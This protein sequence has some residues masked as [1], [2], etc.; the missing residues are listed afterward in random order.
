MAGVSSS[1]HPRP[2]QVTL[3]GWM[4][5][6]GSVLVVFSVVEQLS[7]MRSLETRQAVETFLDEP[8]G[9]ALGL[10]VEAVLTLWRTAALV[11]AGCATAAVVLGWHVLRRHRGARVG[12]TVLALPLFLTGVATG[13]F[14][15]ALVAAASLM[16]WMQP[17]R[18][19]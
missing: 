18:D 2:S 15:S 19:W 7:G 16:L 3:T 9:Q 4:I 5:I 10:D 8:A 11:A 17:A 14:L 12:L 6:V 1:T 13:G